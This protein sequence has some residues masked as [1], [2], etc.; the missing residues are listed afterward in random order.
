MA[1]P[2][3][4]DVVVPP[5][6]QRPRVIVR[7]EPAADMG[8]QADSERGTGR[9]SV[10]RNVLHLFY[11]QTTTWVLATIVAVVQ[12]RFLG[13]D[14]Q[15]QLRLAFSIWALAQ[16]VINLGTSNLLTLEI[17]RNREK[18][19]ALIGPVLAMRLAVY[20]VSMAGI[21]IVAAATGAGGR[22]LAVVA[23]F[24]ATSLFVTVS[25]AVRAALIGFEHMSYP[26]VADVVAKLFQTVAV[27][28][29]LVT[30]ADVRAVAATVAAG[31]LLNAA[32]MV[33]FLRRFP[34]VS[35]RPAWRLT[36]SILK[37]SAGFFVAEAVLIVYQQVDTV[38]LSFL[39]DRRELG[40]YSTS[41]T[42]FASL[43]F[44]PTILLA[45]LLPVIGRLH[46]DD[47][48]R[49]SSMVERTFATLLLVGV[50]VGLGTAV[51]AHPVSLLLYGEKYRQTGSVLTL[52]GI[53]LIFVFITILL[54][55]VA[56]ATG[57]QRF[58]NTL[59]IAAIVLAVPLDL[60]FVPWAEH[61]YGNGAI[62][63]GMSYLLTEGLMFGVGVWKIA[64]QVLNRATAIRSAKILLGGAALVAAAWP[65][66]NRLILL[67]VLAGAAAY[68]VMVVVLR[69]L[70]PDERA[71]F[72]R[73]RARLRA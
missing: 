40:W 32:L 41:D 23:L 28:A 54:G 3:I 49:L 17:A 64:P 8:Q 6:P 27:V 4:R 67:P 18:G 26:A 35:F 53:V 1:D 65:L 19:A 30:S 36:R 56:I 31:G 69:V 46:V 9:Q 2:L 66:R 12:P 61:R 14:A 34:F 52:M 58:W 29:V 42:L 38:M 51:V 16:V 5:P 70:G 10:V 33:H 63:G 62:G 25:T 13:P 50:P 7:T 72:G 71:Q 57:R 60:L 21:L 59:M 48:D 73:L 11:S 37:M 43:L 20:V 15:G 39:V 22:F 47:P 55:Q 68:G 45:S 44:V 24:G